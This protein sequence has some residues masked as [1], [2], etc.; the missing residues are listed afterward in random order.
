M[1]I[2]KGRRTHPSAPSVVQLEQKDLPVHKS[3]TVISELSM[4][5]S[6][7]CVDCKRGKDPPL[8]DQSVGEAEEKSISV[9]T[10]VLLYLIE[11]CLLCCITQIFYMSH[12]HVLY[13]YQFGHI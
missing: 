3:Y 6:Y 4:M 1:F 2:L 9:H 8:T 7:L 13:L 5:G 10:V 11:F 12:Y